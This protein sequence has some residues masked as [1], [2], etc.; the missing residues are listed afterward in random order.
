MLREVW[1]YQPGAIRYAKW[2]AF[3]L[4]VTLDDEYSADQ[5]N[6]FLYP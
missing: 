5:K 4:Q 3:A 1:V 6:L 2:I